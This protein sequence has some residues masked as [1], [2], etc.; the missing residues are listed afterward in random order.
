[1]TNTKKII[2]IRHCKAEM[3][4]VDRERKL[5]EDGV[6]QSKSLGKKLNNLLSKEVRV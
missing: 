3:G 4:G 2:F 6:I 5:D 1:M